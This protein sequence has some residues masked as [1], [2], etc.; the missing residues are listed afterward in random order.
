MPPTI[1]ILKSFS[2]VEP[3]IDL[4]SKAADSERDALGFLPPNA[5][6]QAALQ[7]KLFVAV[8][9]DGLFLGYLMFGGV[10]PHGKV[11]Q[12]FSIPNAR[13]H[14]IARTLLEELIEHLQIRGYLSISARVA[15]DLIDSNE[16][17]EKLNFHT[18]GIVRG[19]KARERVI[20]QR[21]RDLD[22]PSLFDFM[23]PQAVDHPLNLGITDS[24]TAKAPIYA[25]D[26]NVLFD[27]SR[28]R[29]NSRDAGMVFR[30]GFNN[31]IRLVIAEE[32]LDELKRSSSQF[33]D[34]PHLRLALQM[35]ILPTPKRKKIES[36]EGSLSGIIF[37]EKKD[38]G[39]LSIQDKS[40]LRHLA[41]AIHHNIQGFITSEKAILRQHDHLRSNYGLDVLGVTDFSDTLPTIDVGP[42]LE[43]MTSGDKTKLTSGSMTEGNL[44]EVVSFLKDIHVPS[45]TIDDITSFGDYI[46]PQRHIVLSGINGVLSFSSWKVEKFPKKTARAF[47]GANEDAPTARTAVDY[48][49]GRI[50]RSAG[51]DAPARIVLQILPG[52]PA[53]KRIAL[54]HGF[55][56]EP[57]KEQ[58]GTTLH[59]VC[60]CGI[61]D[62]SS[63]EHTRKSITSLIGANLPK[64]IPPFTGTNQAITIEKPT[65]Q[66]EIIS[67]Q[68]LETLIS[69]AHVLLPGRSGAIVP[70]KRVFADE[71]LGTSEQLT[72]LTPTEAVFLKER[73]YYSSPRAAS[74]LT[75]GTPILFYESSKGGG[76]MSVVAIARVIRSYL[77]TPDQLNSDTERKGVLDKSTL[78]HFGRSRTKLVTVFDN[79]MKFRKPVSLN[80]LREIGCADG[81][82]F[83]TAKRLQPGELSMVVNEGFADG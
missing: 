76:R 68:E 35:E 46:A 64:E 34:D 66:Q 50:C 54:A 14:G 13:R 19:G 53:T 8:D 78:E 9:A 27:V 6:K 17:Y 28:Q 37:K 58:Y 5:Y 75:P 56:T 15:S 23:A 4:A 33:P 63:W 44:K 20:N 40:D 65:G 16:F 59:K 18:V 1:K 83:V 49:I 61:V 25:M 48:T 29:V 72:L 2:D 52:H 36:I 26:L 43:Q 81:A 10:F 74:I 71:L 22:T 31:E 24:Y 7:E 45:K 69:P 80:R 51:K 73:V 82:N 11:M 32:F 30:A 55:R 77:A 67:L 47:I 12:I 21:V 38:K 70:I 3:Y 60:I 79:V 42:E 57:G 41:T 62:K 39:T